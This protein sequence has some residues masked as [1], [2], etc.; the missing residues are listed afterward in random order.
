MRPQDR[1][2]NGAV[3]RGRS[4]HQISSR[5]RSRDLS[6]DF[7]D[8]RSHRY[9]DERDMRDG[10]R[11]DY[12]HRSRSIDR[13]ASSHS[14]R[15]RS[16]DPPLSQY[17]SSS[18]PSRDHSYHHQLN[19]SHSRK[20]SRSPDHRHRNLSIGDGNHSSR[21]PRRFG[22]GKPKDSRYERHLL[23]STTGAKMQR[24][25]PPMRSNEF[26][27]DENTKNYANTSY[28]G[29][30]NNMNRYGYDSHYYQPQSRYVHPKSTS[31]SRERRPLASRQEPSFPRFGQQSS[32][33]TASPRFNNINNIPE[34]IQTAHA[35][36]A[37]MTPAATAAFWNNV[38]KQ[39]GATRQSNP[40]TEQMS[41]HL[42]HIFE[43]TQN[44]LR[45]FDMKDLSQIIYSMAK[46]VVVLR[47]LGGNRR[48][49]DIATVLSDLLLN[50]GMAI[51]E[52]LFRSFASA[53]ADKLHQFNPQALSNT[54]WAYATAGINHP[55]L[56]E[57]MA[58]HI[59]AS[60]RLDRFNPQALKDTVWAYATAQ[61]SHPML[62]QKVAK[63]AIQR[64]EEINNSRCCQSVVGIRHHGHC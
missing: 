17:A 28:G 61:V 18:S 47:K 54:V 10:T 1:D 56:F 27:R 35:N 11:G 62:F 8:R 4:S 5:G 64:K 24:A 59:V 37:A 6:Y 43:Y 19:S 51:S 50:H 13:Y 16:C 49:G 3:G 55:K 63:A 60:D 9:Y 45:F 21:R 14:H 20:R 58:N 36:L 7:H 22:G 41:S 26:H 33:S 15:S 53:A 57:K 52:D 30:V 38:S 25:H 31:Q 23:K 39:M 34:M 46:L 12:Y 42:K 40:Y 44:T 32:W 48:G 2:G 29:G